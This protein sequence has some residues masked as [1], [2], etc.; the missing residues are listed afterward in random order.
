[1]R[2]TFFPPG[3]SASI[4]RSHWREFVEARDSVLM[5][6]GRPLLPSELLDKGPELGPLLAS[7]ERNREHW[8]EKVQP[9]LA[10][11]G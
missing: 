11:L 4:R 8:G 9:L 6:L 1:M 3:D 7:P 10:R 5:V 2:Q